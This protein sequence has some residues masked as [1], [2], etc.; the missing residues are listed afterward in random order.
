MSVLK[1]QHLMGALQSSHAPLPLPPPPP[2]TLLL[3]N[4]PVEFT[5]ERAILLLLLLHQL[6]ALLALFRRVG[7]LGVYK[8]VIGH[9]LAIMS[10]AVPGVA[11]LVASEEK[12]ALADLEKDLLGD[13]DPTAVTALPEHSIKAEELEK[14][15]GEAMRADAARA[16]Q[17]RWGGIYHNSGGTLATL[18]GHIWSQYVDTNALYPGV[19]PSL[20]K[21]EAEVIAMT[22]SIVHGHEAGA[23]GLLASGG[24]ESV[25]LAAL[26]YRETG[27]ARGITEPQIICAISAH[28]AITKACHYFG[29]ELIKVPLEPS[30]MSLRA[31]AVRPYLSSQTVAIYASAPSFAH[32]VIDAIEELG[33]LA[34][35]ARVGLH[36]D[37]CLGGFL[38]SFMAREGILAK[39]FDFAV[40]GVSSM[41]ID[42]HKYGCAPKGVSVVAFRTAELR[43][44]TYVPSTDGCEGLYVTPT[45]QGSRSGAIMATAWATM[46]HVGGAGYAAKAREISA[47][48]EKIKAFVKATPPL[49]LCAD[50]DACTVPV[51][52]DTLNVYALATLLEQKGWSVFTGQKPATVTFPLGDQTPALVDEL[53][54]DLGESVGWLL[55]HPDFKP[56]GNAAVYGMASVA[57][58]AVLDSILRGYVD[59]TL[60]VKPLN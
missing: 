28:P 6:S 24:T 12:K 10:A 45:L 19:F 55:A 56:K 34:L 32:G 20:R 35:E 36:V 18:Q 58:D 41:S 7:F 14:R 4:Y 3:T 16:T 40:P 8:Y 44:A 39:P 26:A 15:T 43:R 22:L 48:H 37:N 38:L 52:S 21:Y 1:V 13:G 59:L 31:A 46:L 57:P 33:A 9:L 53:L 11:S 51:C 5:V 30:S 50:S 49:R 2:P 29:I 54:R 23:C 17:K 25:L 27:R 47:C 42:V 60:K